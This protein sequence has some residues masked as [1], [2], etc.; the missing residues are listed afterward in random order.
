MK[1]LAWIAI[2]ILVVAALVAVRITRVREKENAPL[3][4]QPLAAP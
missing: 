4:A 3:V 1:K 2:I